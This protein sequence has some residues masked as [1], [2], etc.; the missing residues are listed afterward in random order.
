MYTTTSEFNRVQM[1]RY[2]GAGTMVKPPI[3]R[4]GSFSYSSNG[5]FS[6]GNSSGLEIFNSTG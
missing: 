1:A 6:D 3:G 4:Y 5:S 2:M